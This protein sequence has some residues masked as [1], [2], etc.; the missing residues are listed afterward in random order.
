MVINRMNRMRAGDHVVDYLGAFST[1]F[2][3]SSP[4][5]FVRVWKYTH[6]SIYTI[7]PSLR[8]PSNPDNADVNQFAHSPSNF[9]FPS[10][11][12]LSSPSL[13][14][15]VSSLG[16]GTGLP[17]L[18]TGIT[19]AETAA[20]TSPGLTMGPEHLLTLLMLL[21]CHG[22]RDIGRM[23]RMWIRMF[24]NRKIRFIS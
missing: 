15:F 17:P 9:D 24:L 18:A 8:L 1:N 19:T 6:S 10:L 21:F 13:P 16:T 2:L 5:P 11:G 22:W 3:L 20:T 7:G 23:Y 4:K 14:G 12:N